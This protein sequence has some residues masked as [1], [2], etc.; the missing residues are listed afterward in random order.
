MKS[1]AVLWSIL[2]LSAVAHAQKFPDYPVRK[3]S[4]YSSCQIKNGIRVAIEAVGDED[5][6]KRYFRTKFGSQGFLPV[7]I[8]LEN[9]SEGSSLLLRKELVAYRINGGTAGDQSGGAPSARSKT[10]E[11]VALAGAA[12]LSLPAMFI[13]LKMIAGA[14]EV[15]QNIFV[16]ELRSQTIAPGKVGNGFIYVPVG[17][18][19][20]EKRRVT[21]I[22]AVTWSDKEES[23]LF[24]FELTVPDDIK[25]LER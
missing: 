21:L 2:L 20:K 23:V 22:V 18:P 1:L 14:S 12:A 9:A 15:K 25:K 24:E 17:K 5:E 3:A 13:G 6:Q 19:G 16:K 7:L 11:G 8:V 10:G 4:E